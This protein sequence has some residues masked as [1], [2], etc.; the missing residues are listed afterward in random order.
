MF[1]LYRLHY[2]TSTNCGLCQGNMTWCHKVRGKDYHWIVDL[3][4]RLNL[5]VVGAVVKALKD[6]MEEREAIL[7]KQKL[8][9]TKKNRIQNKIAR[10]DD[11]AERKRWVKRQSLQHT[12]GGDEDGYD[13]EDDPLL[14]AEADSLI[15]DL[16]GEDGQLTT[17]SGK[18]CRCGSFLHQ[19]TSH[20]A[21]PL[22]KASHGQKQD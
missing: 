2:I 20:R 3:Y 12:Y 14:V 22:N 1:V 5:P 21:C 9:E 13:G 4:Q 17:I 18:K 8:E 10:A 7:E 11:Q 16:G 15:S 6:A 19:R